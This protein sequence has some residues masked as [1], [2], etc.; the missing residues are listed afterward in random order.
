MSKDRFSS[1]SKQYAAFRPTYPQAL[2]DFIMKFVIEKQTAWDCACGNGQVARDLSTR[3]HKV[4]ATDQSEAQLANAVPKDNIV[5]LLSSAERTPFEDKQFDLIT[6]GQAIH[7][8]NIPAFF[9]EARRVSKPGG[10][11]AIWGY[12]LLSV[13][14]KIDPIID[15]F[16][17]SVVGPYWDPER[18]L[19]DRRYSTIEFPFGKI[20]APNFEFSFDWTLEEL[21]G[22]LSTWSSVQKFIK[23]N[24]RN[25]VADLMTRIEPLWDTPT[26]KVSFPLFTLL[27]RIP[28]F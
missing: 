22:Y 21:S 25:P 24:H 3:F 8:F 10:I 23:Q 19:V 5:Y 9:E 27:G 7:W 4:Y 11:L 20:E 6:V 17:S 28:P 16:Y 26:K 12:S 13:D 14:E 1:H 2:Y 15:H 18:K